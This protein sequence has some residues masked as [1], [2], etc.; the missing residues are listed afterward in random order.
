[1]A[2]TVLKTH[3]TTHMVLRVKSLLFF[4]RVWRANCMHLCQPDRKRRSKRAR[5]RE[6]ESEGERE[7]R[8]KKRSKVNR[9]GSGKA[10][11]VSLCRPRGPRVPVAVRCHLAHFLSS[12]PPGR[13]TRAGPRRERHPP[14]SATQRH[15]APPS[16]TLHKQPAQPA[17]CIWPERG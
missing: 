11:T 6:R 16:T 13:V 10:L 15:P 5:K 14:P 9:R 1:M 2:Y 12:L 17:G 7:D 4:S 8:E 3:G